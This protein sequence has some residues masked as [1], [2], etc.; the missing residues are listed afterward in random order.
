MNTPSLSQWTELRDAYSRA[1]L[2]S[3]SR[4]H[5]RRRQSDITNIKDRAQ[6]G[7]HVHSNGSIVWLHR[8]M[9]QTEKRELKSS[10]DECGLYAIR[11]SG[12]QRGK[13][14]EN[15]CLNE[16]M[17]EEP[18][19]NRSEA[20][21]LGVTAT[22]THSR[23]RARHGAQEIMPLMRNFLTESRRSRATAELHRA[24]D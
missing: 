5:G 11:P 19:E 24:T 6:L 17:M 21:D 7:L 14:S 1:L 23:S 2:R 4:T 12:L 13:Q 10:A 8:E 20:M 16:I 18:A 22:A 15:T 9:G 3:A